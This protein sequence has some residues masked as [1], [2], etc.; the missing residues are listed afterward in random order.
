MFVVTAIALI[1]LLVMASGT[2]WI[3]RLMPPVVTGAVVTVIGRR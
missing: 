1:G 3:K 2:A